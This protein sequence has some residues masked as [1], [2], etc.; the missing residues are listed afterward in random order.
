MCLSFPS[1]RKA[2]I[3]TNLECQESI[4]GPQ[5]RIGSIAC[6]AAPMTAFRRGGKTDNPPEH[7]LDIPLEV[8]QGL[9]LSS[10]AEDGYRYLS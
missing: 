7:S 9:G 5:K 4:W 6:F 1:L 10:S 2:G 8:Y 3:G